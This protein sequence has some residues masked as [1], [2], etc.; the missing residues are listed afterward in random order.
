MITFR[1]DKEKEILKRDSPERVEKKELERDFP[2]FFN[3][4]MI[5]NHQT[6]RHEHSRFGNVSE[7]TKKRFLELFEEGLTASAAWHAFR[8]EIKENNPDNFHILFGNRRV[9]PDY[10]WPHKFFAK[11][12]ED[13]IGSFGG[14][15]GFQT[16]DF[17]SPQ[18][19]F[20]L[21]PL[22]HRASPECLAS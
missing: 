5:H 4:N 14:V 1:L 21:A 11:W 13:K 16:K 3:F 15:D 17:H 12:I 9:V 7:E 10:F 8:D 19:Y 2:L 20:H 6:N 18:P 22:G